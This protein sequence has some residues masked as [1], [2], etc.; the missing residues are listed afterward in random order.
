M[1]L[2]ATCCL[3]PRR[4]KESCFFSYAFGSITRQIKTAEKATFYCELKKFTCDTKVAEKKSIY[5]YMYIYLKLTAHKRY[6][7]PQ[8]ISKYISLLE[9]ALIWHKKQANLTECEKHTWFLR[10]CLK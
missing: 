5:I 1:I 8:N 6:Y 3:P 10:M 2:C 4:P 7:E 9:N